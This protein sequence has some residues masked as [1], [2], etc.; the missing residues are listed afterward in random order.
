MATALCLPPKPALLALRAK[1]TCL[2]DPEAALRRLRFWDAAVLK[3]NAW[4]RLWVRYARPCVP[5]LP[6]DVLMLLGESPLTSLAATCRSL[7]GLLLPRLIRAKSHA[8]HRYLM[9]L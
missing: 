7:R 8:Q 6:E 2:A 9:S 5:A 3:A 1:R 4:S